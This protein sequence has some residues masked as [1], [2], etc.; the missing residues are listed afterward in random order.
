MKYLTILI[1]A[2]FLFACSDDD[3][4]NSTAID[5][6]L[7]IEVINDSE[8]NMFN[9]ATNDNFDIENIRFYELAENNET[10]LIYNG[11]WDYPYGFRTDSNFNGDILIQ[12]G[13]LPNAGNTYPEYIAKWTETKQDTI[14]C[15]VEQLSN[16]LRFSKVWVNE[17][18]QWESS[19]QTERKITIE[20][21]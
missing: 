13:F 2:V 17:E 7:T 11:N 10:T 21:E 4:P 3:N 14:K 6:G 12:T 8:E 15:E 9:P 5:V 19:S 18:L 16:V 1:I 20:I